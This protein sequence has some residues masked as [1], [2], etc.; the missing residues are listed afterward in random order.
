MKVYFQKAEEALIDKLKR[1]LKKIIM[2]KAAGSYSLT[3]NA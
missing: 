1:N 2:G 3:G